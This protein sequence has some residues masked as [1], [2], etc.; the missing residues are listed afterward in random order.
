MEECKRV[1]CVGGV[2]RIC[3]P[4]I[5]RM[6]R[7]MTDEYREAVRAGGHGDNPI[8]AAIFSHGHQGAWTQELLVAF[9][10]GVGFDVEPSIY[11]VSNHME[12]HQIDGHH[13]VVGHSIAALET[14][15]VEGTKC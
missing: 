6:T 11:N 5:A 3:V 4:D 10:K 14:S 12:L 15:V 8:K 9:L 1:L 2:V 7:L 13:K